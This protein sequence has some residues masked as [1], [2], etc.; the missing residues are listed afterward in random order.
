MPCRCSRLAT[1]SDTEE[2]AVLPVTDES[3]GHELLAAGLSAAR[4]GDRDA[5]EAAAA[6]LDADADGY[7]GVMHKQVAALLEAD[8]GNEA[9][10]G[11]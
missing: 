4:T 5:L 7:A 6:A 3:S 11:G 8:R 2:W 9:A 10:P 1:S